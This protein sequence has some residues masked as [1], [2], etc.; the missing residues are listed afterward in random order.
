MLGIR[1]LVPL[2][3]EHH[4]RAY[5]VSKWGLPR[6]LTRVAALELSGRGIRANA[7][8]PGRIDTPILDAR[9]RCSRRPASTRP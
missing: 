8:H 1:T 9:T 7:V 2:M 5:T 6:G 3:P 4:A